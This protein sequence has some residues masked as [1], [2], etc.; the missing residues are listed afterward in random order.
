MEL[1]E[2]HIKPGQLQNWF[3][4][5]YTESCHCTFFVNTNSALFCLC[6]W[7][8]Q[9]NL[10]SRVKHIIP[11]S[12][13]KNTAEQPSVCLSLISLIFIYTTLKSSLQCYVGSPHGAMSSDSLQRGPLGGRGVSGFRMFRS[14]R[15]W[16][17]AS[18]GQ[19]YSITYHRCYIGQGTGECGGLLT[20]VGSVTCKEPA[21]I[22]FVDF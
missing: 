19:D 10:A 22:T 2:I 11:K 18:V 5:S 17:K 21:L 8:A 16:N 7:H 12:Q 20:A 1:W 9:I 6:W 4:C 3:P 14:C 15:L 13:W